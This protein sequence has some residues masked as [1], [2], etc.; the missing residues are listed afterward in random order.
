MK[1]I[2]LTLAIVLGITLGA[3]AQYKGLFDRGPEAGYQNDSY[4]REGEGGI[5]SLPTSHGM[6]GDQESPLGSGA[7]LLI[8]F[9]AAYALRK[10]DRN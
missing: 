4:N 1:R 8:G 9:G 10:K 6:D 7:L 5:L 3:S 2:A